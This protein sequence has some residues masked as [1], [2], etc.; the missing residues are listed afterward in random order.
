MYTFHRQTIFAIELV[1]QENWYWTSRTFKKLNPQFKYDFNSNI[2][3][4]ITELIILKIA[5]LAWYLF[6]FACISGINGMFIRV[7]L[8]CSAIMIFPMIY[9]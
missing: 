9:I 2:P 5:K 7:S 8:K 3:L 4:M 6:V 1:S